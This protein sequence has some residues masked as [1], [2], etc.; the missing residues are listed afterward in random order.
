[1]LPYDYNTLFLIQ[2]GMLCAMTLNGVFLNQAVEVSCKVK[3][4]LLGTFVAFHLLVLQIFANGSSSRLTA[5][6]FVYI[7]PS[8]RYNA[9]Q[10]H[11]G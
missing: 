2:Q 10:G 8:D 3:G 7:V 4:L 5:F 11:A 6:Q 1:M 9:Y